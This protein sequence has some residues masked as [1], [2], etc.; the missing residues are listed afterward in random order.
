ML[1]KHCS[2]AGLSISLTAKDVLKILLPTLCEL[3]S[4]FNV[5]LKTFLRHG[6]SKPEFYGDLEYKFKKIVGRTD[7]SGQFKKIIIRT[8]VLATI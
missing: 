4:K 5:C 7:F 3:L 6:I 8:N 2:T 1:F